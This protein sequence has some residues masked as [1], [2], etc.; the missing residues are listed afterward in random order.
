[1][2]ILQVWTTAESRAHWD[3]GEF[4]L[5]ETA[6]ED[7]AA[8]AQHVDAGGMLHGSRLFVR[9]GDER[10]ESIVVS[11]HPIMLHPSA[12]LRM[13]LPIWRFVEETA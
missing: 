5:I 13:E 1:M 9:R 10:N 3:R 8:A 7:F 6:H 2:T 11:R 12:I 4:A